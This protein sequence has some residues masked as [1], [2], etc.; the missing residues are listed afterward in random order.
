MRRTLS[1]IKT[2]N[3][4]IPKLRRNEIAAFTMIARK[5]TGLAALFA[6][7]ALYRH[8]STADPPHAIFA[9][10]GPLYMPVNTNRVFYVKHLSHSIFADLLGA[11]P[12]V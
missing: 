11:R 8:S 9:P 1:Q 7:S 2:G 4:G 10:R 5:I 12:D 6:R 3:C